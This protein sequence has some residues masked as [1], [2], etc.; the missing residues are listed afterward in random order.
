MYNEG[1][2]FGKRFWGILYSRLPVISSHIIFDTHMGKY[3]E[4]DRNDTLDRH[5]EENLYS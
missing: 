5:D 2:I 1:S 4:H 3:K